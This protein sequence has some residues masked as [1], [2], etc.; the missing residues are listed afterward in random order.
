MEDSPL[1]IAANIAGLLTFVV[2]ILASVYVRIVSLR[3]GR[4][5]LDTIRESVSDMV[6]DLVQMKVRNPLP[7]LRESH[8]NQE[9][10][11]DQEGD[12]LDMNRLKRMTASFI[13]TDI[14]IYVYCM[15]AIDLDE[16]AYS[17]KALQPALLEAHGA[18]S[19]STKFSEATIEIT[20]IASGRDIVE[21]GI[22]FF[23]RGVPDDWV[24]LKQ[25]VDASYRLLTAGSSP[26]LIRWY[27]MREKVL[28]K[29]RRR[30]M[31]RSR[32]LTQ[33]VEMAHV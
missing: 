28:V 8:G 33:Q 29:V 21:R 17:V 16:A 7:G 20:T 1:S 27:R 25:V 12:E 9:G 2:A 4:I 32:I 14:V 23:A 13:V 5:E 26:T 19:T 31:L 18:S 3:N 24:F 6:D 15:H 10:N 11:G 30:D 22:D